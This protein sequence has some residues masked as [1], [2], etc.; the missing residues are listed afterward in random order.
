MTLGGSDTVPSQELRQK[1]AIN[2]ILGMR[3]QKNQTS[4]WTVSLKTVYLHGRRHTINVPVPCWQLACNASAR[5]PGP[6][7]APEGNGNRLHFILEVGSEC[8]QTTFWDMKLQQVRLAPELS[9]WKPFYLYEHRY[10]V[11]FW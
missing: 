7:L 1:G 10:A 11:P 3:L 9:V 8:I 5:M 6:M 2:D 4:S